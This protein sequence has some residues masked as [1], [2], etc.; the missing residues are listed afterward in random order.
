VL[1]GEDI[2][3]KVFPKQEYY[4]SK[5]EEEFQNLRRLKHQNIVKLIGFCNETENEYTEFKGVQVSANRI[6]LA[7][8]LEYVHNGSLE[9]YI[10]GNLVLCPAGVFSL[11]YI[12][13]NSRV[14]F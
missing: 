2:A 5:F 3:V 1:D 11:A 8:C 4:N 12:T 14:R 10:A 13:M 9:N 6:H 7:L